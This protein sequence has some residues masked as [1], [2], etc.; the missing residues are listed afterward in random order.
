MMA[1]EKRK[2][3]K[4]IYD[5][6]DSNATELFELSQTI[7]D[8]P[9]L[10][11]KEYKAHEVLTNILEKNGFTVHRSSYLETAFTATYQSNVYKTGN[12]IYLT[13][14]SK[15]FRLQPK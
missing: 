10:A 7:W 5:T 9:E 14:C 4:H 2:Q 13:T 12:L 15:P 3:L 11:L 6:I 8:N 1:D